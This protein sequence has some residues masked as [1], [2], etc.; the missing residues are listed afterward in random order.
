[1][2]VSDHK[3]P[4]HERRRHDRYR[5]NWPAK[6]LVGGEHVER[7][8]VVDVSCGGMGLDCDLPVKTGEKLT[9]ELPQI[10][11]FR[12]V[13]AWKGAN[14][15]GVQFLNEEGL[16]DGSLDQLATCLMFQPSKSDVV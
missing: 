13:V 10:G 5:V 6:C 14:R 11:I 9:V 2:P 7:V 15:C 1:M 4:G 12:C 3:L 16:R 8:N